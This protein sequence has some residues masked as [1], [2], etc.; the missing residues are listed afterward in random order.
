MLFRLRRDERGFTMVTVI[1]SLL[2]VTLLAVT[3]LSYAQNDLPSGADD[4]DRKIAYAAAEAG[5][6]NYLYY[7]TQ[8]TNYWARCAP[9]PPG[10]PTHVNE[11]WNG[12]GNDPRRWAR[13]PGMPDPETLPEAKKVWYTIELLP[14][15]GHTTC[16][17]TS[18]EASMIDTATKTFSIRTTGRVG[19]TGEKRSIVTRFRRQS[20]LDYVY[21]T[22][23]ETLSPV[24]APVQVGSR[25]T[26]T[27][28]GCV[29]DAC[30]DLR[31]WTSQEC[32]RYYGNRPE[33]SGI[34]LAPDGNRQTQT[35][36]GQYYTG[37]S[38]SVYNFSG[39]D[40]LGLSFVDDDVTAGQ[41]H[42]NDEFNCSGTPR[43]GRG[44]YDKIQTASLGQTAVPALGYRSGCSPNLVGTA[45]KNAAKVEI[46]PT[47]EGLHRDTPDG[48]RFVGLTKIKLNG[49]TMNVIGT[50]EDGTPYAATGALPNGPS[51]PI[52]P[53]G[54]VYVANSPT[55][56]CGG[57][58]VINPYQLAANNACG[59]LEVK[60]NYSVSA[61]LTAENDIVV[62][63]DINRP[64]GSPPSPDALLG[65]I[66]KN[67]I[68]VYHPVTGCGTYGCNFLD[69]CTNNGSASPPGPGSITIDAAILSLNH[70]FVVDNFHCGAQ[71][72]TLT[73]RGAIVQKF[74]GP[75]GMSSTSG[76]TKAY[77]YDDRLA[78][79]APPKFLDPVKSA[80]RVQTYSEQVPAR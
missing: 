64:T 11:R 71:L 44:S 55:F 31:T 60:G 56:T 15:N 33:G 22:D 17:V 54:V 73:V 41:F 32:N 37:S 27:P 69:T 66:S 7:L 51:M 42:T 25:A 24:L 72:G 1:G 6:Q 4:R 68:R 39:E 16:S 50:G 23:K 36:S 65:L 59:N 30:R 29:L 19:L 12:L 79:R 61:T 75:V 43:F 38:W 62:M 5:A 46:P 78:Y 57:Y 70:S 18:P 74:R 53:G 10:T 13:V 77:S 40:C 47:N 14:A 3:A 80:W 9:T 63:E 48:Y 20:L 76:Y 58:N 8:D 49:T 67:F 34:E 21:L 28:S 26:R 35:F 45:V 52:P 2:V